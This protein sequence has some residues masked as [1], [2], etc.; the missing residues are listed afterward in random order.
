MNDPTMIFLLLACL[1]IAIIGLTV[2]SGR[3]R[4]AID[5][6][7]ITEFLTANGATSISIFTEPFDRYRGTNT[8]DVE[9]TDKQ[10]QQ[11]RNRCQINNDL[12]STDSSLYWKEPM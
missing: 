2:F 9:Y 12:Y 7:R 8:Y 5:R 10:G 3:R 1:L 6:R 11:R 4:V